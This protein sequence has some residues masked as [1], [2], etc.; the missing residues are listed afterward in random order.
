MSKIKPLWEILSTLNFLGLSKEKPYMQLNSTQHRGQV[1]A[2]SKRDI[3]NNPR[4]SSR[5]V[6]AELHDAGME[7]SISTVKGTL[8]EAELKACRPRKVP[9]LKPRHLATI[10]FKVCKGLPEADKDLLAHYSLVR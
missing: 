2:V 5:E 6:T 9:L 1:G 3:R 8:H 7:V 10:K 4:K